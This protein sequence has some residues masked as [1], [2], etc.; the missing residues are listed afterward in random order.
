MPAEWRFAFSSYRSTQK[1]FWRLSE[2]RQMLT[3]S[4]LSVFAAVS[5]IWRKMVAG[6][7]AWTVL[8]RVRPI[9]ADCWTRNRCALFR[10]APSAASRFLR[11]RRMRYRSEP[12]SPSAKSVG[13]A[14]FTMAGLSSN[15][16]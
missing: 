15:L 6:S 3:R 13:T 4:T 14:K 5:V 9:S 16:G 12:N 1:I 7:E 10:S 11:S 8:L 2:Y